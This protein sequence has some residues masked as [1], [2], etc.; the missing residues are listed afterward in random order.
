MFA[1][2]EIRDLVDIVPGK[3]M[4]LNAVTAAGTLTVINVHGLGS[5]GDIGVSKASFWANVAMYA[6]PKTAGG[7]RVVLIGG[8][9]N[10]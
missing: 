7:L 6:A 10:V 5:I 1:A 2:E 9:F 8:D 3:A 4:A